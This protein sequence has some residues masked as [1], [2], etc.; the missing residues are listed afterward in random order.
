MS[1][2]EFWTLVVAAIGALAWLPSIL[3]LFEKSEIEG[4]LLSRYSNINKDRT[5]S[6]FLF[7]IS[8]FSKNKPFDL[9]NIS[10]EF[11]FENGE[12]LSANASNNR[13][14]VFTFDTTYKLLLTGEEFINNYSFLPANE[15][16]VGYL[17]F[18]PNGDLDHKLN[19]T[20]FIFESFDN[21]TQKVVF[22]E[23]SIHEE[24]LFFDD[25]IWKPID[26]KE[27]ENHP[28]FKPLFGNK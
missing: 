20:T 2:L 24:Q 16:K 17:Y 28:A 19:S 12:K 3:S 7:K 21:K 11:E 5:Q 22:Q 4:K 10:C 18:Q 9:K 23:K 8:L 6:M 13:V 27:I 15:N 1:K 14:T 26:R 25:T